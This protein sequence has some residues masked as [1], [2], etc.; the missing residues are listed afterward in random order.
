[1]TQV[2]PSTG[3]RS[4]RTFTLRG[5]KSQCS[6]NS[7]S[8]LNNL[9]FVYREIG[10]RDVA[11]LPV[12]PR[13]IKHRNPDG[14]RS[15]SGNFHS[16][17]RVFAYQIPEYRS[18]DLSVSRHLYPTK[19]LGPTLPRQL[20]EFADRESIMHR[21]LPLENPECRN[22][23]TP[24]SCHLSTLRPT[25]P[26]KSGNRTSRLRRAWDYCT[27]QPRSADTKREQSSPRLR[28]NLLAPSPRSND[29]RDF[30]SLHD[31]S[32][33]R[34][35]SSMKGSPLHHLRSVR[36]PLINSQRIKR[37][38]LPEL[39]STQTPSEI[40]QPLFPYSVFNHSPKVMKPLGSWHSRSQELPSS[41][42]SFA[43]EA[44]RPICTHLHDWDNF[45]VSLGNREQKSNY[46]ASSTHS[47]RRSFTA[48]D[49]GISRPKQR[50]N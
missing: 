37:D 4:T 46:L 11:R 3:G 15:T 39:F 21:S 34:F 6:S 24:D 26:I 38:I 36:P 44:P 20:R 22:P 14:R 48:L 7:H 32:S 30:A 13:A 8:L 16:W 43:T 35:S 50:N 2:H 31:D 28:I 18:V 5:P 29:P 27:R 9:P 1:V 49:A 40:S 10:P 41:L 25:V 12:L 47:M 19:Y 45:Q 23:D 17:R 33:R 42:L